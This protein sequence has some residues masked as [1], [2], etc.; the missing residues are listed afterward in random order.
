MS[1]Q[2]KQTPVNHDIV[3]RHTNKNNK[4]QGKQRS[5]KFEIMVTYCWQVHP[6]A[7]A[8]ETWQWR[9]STIVL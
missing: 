3:E 2:R 6:A 1:E 4:N 5:A 8:M 7:G 9:F